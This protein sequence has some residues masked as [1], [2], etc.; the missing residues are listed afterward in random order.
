MKEITVEV[1]DDTKA[2]LVE[3]VNINPM[4]DLGG[5]VQEVIEDFVKDNEGVVSPPVWIKVTSG[6]PSTQPAL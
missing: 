2:K 4:S 1:D 5:R 3:I 6:S